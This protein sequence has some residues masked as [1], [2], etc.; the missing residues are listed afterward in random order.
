MFY[1]GS[2][3]VGVFSLGVELVYFLFVFILNFKDLEDRGE[4]KV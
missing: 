1:F 4:V 3:L 2:F